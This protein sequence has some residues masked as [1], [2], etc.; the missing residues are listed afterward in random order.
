MRGRMYGNAP[1]LVPPVICALVTRIEDKESAKVSRI[2]RRLRARGLIAKIPRT[3]R[4]RVTAYGRRV[5]G[6]ALYLRDHDYPRAYS[7]I[8]A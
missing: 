2:F 7:Q 8:P 3:R 6:T 5:M 4:W 1:D